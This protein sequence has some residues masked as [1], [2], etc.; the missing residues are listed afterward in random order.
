MNS[1]NRSSVGAGAEAWAEPYTEVA[2]GLADRGAEVPKC[3]LE[4]LELLERIDLLNFFLARFRVT[5]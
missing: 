3:V 4:E 2:F 1:L 5:I